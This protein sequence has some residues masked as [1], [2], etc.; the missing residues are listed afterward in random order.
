MIFFLSK[1]KIRKFGA[2][3]VFVA[4]VLGGLIG[5]FYSLWFIDVHTFDIVITPKRPGPF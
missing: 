3:L 2:E 4:I 5:L 1:K